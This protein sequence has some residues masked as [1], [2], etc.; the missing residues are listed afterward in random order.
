MKRHELTFLE[1]LKFN[2]I[3]KNYSLWVINSG[4]MSSLNIALSELS[5]T[6]VLVYPPGL[7]ITLS[8][9]SSTCPLYMGNLIM[10]PTWQISLVVISTSQNIPWVISVSCSL[11]KDL[12]LH[13]IIIMILSLSYMSIICVDLPVSSS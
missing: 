8:L 12:S 6:H 13:L 4:S 3:R 10:S 2:K 7:A 9:Y 11:F 5:D 1:L